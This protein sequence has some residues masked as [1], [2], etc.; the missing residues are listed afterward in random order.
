MKSKH[1]LNLSWSAAVRSLEVLS[2][3]LSSN[4]AHA[5]EYTTMLDRTVQAYL[6]QTTLQNNF[7]QQKYQMLTNSIQSQII[8]IKSKKSTVRKS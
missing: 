8:N 6:Q 1:T 5:I 3:R 7:K 4:I 2:E